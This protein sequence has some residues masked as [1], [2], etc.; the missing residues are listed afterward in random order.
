MYQNYRDC[1]KDD[2]SYKN[3][4]NLDIGIDNKYNIICLMIFE[5]YQ[6][7]LNSNF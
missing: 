2:R 3:V 1:F 7:N 6:G 4:E 5:Y